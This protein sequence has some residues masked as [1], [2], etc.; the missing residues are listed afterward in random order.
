VV[1]VGSTVVNSEPSWR[2]SLVSHAVVGHH[3]WMNPSPGSHTDFDSSSPV[4]LHGFSVSGPGSIVGHVALGGLRKISFLVGRNNHGKSTLL[5]ATQLFS[6]NGT[7]DKKYVSRHLR[8][9]AAIGEQVDPLRKLLIRVSSDQWPKQVRYRDSWDEMCT[10]AHEAGVAKLDGTE[11]LIW[12]ALSEDALTQPT[13]QELSIDGWAKALGFRPDLTS[14]VRSLCSTGNISQPAGVAS[15]PPRAFI[16]AFREIRPATAEPPDPIALDSGVG[17]AKLLQRWQNPDHMDFE[18][19]DNFRLFQS[20]NDL[21]KDVLEDPSAAI[22]I[23]FDARTIQ[24]QTGQASRVL[25]I[26]ELGDGIKQAIIIGTAALRHTETLV[27]LEEPEIH[28]H[29]GMQRKLI[30]HL[31]DRTSNQYIIATHSMAM[32]DIGGAAVFHVIHDGYST[33]ATEPIVVDDVVRIGEDL[34]YRASDLLLA[35]YV[36][37][38]EGPADRL[39]W[40]RWL[41]LFDAE[42]D[43]GVHYSIVSYGGKLIAGIDISSGDRDQGAEGGDVDTSRDLVDLLKLGRQC[44]LIADSDK[45]SEGEPLNAT[46]EWVRSTAGS[47]ANVIIPEWVRT[48]ENLLPSDVLQAAVRQVRP[49]AGKGYIAPTDPFAQPFSSLANEP[50]KVAVARA[51]VELLI[52]PGCVSDQHAVLIRDL[53]ERIRKA[54]GLLNRPSAGPLDAAG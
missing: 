14:M 19:R 20:L 39:Y 21:L 10:R 44:T 3:G 46:L 2:E 45:S 9:G 31:R 7:I 40:R 26:D 16:P 28:L 23:P 54:N 1:D 51:A 6:A 32:L 50:P 33:A 17:L 8:K 30:K 52:D 41:K 38:V 47:T 13:I 4:L 5:R 22:S 36:I 43:E 12:I 24:V 53:A 18:Q 25:D 11:L 15:L 27:C 35:N 48:V 37:W 42:I 34:G 49:R 29:P